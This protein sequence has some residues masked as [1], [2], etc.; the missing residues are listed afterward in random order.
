M[1][2]EKWK[3]KGSPQPS[4]AQFKGDVRR[5]KISR[6]GDKHSQCCPKQ[7]TYI[8]SKKGEQKHHKDHD[9]RDVFVGLIKGLALISLERVAQRQV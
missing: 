5:E 7:P 4:L 1:R 3:M 2:Y 9:Q 6:N 8:D